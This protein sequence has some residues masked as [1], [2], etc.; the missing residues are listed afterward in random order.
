MRG[1]GEIAY[2][3]EVARPH[4]GVITNVGARAPRDG[5]GS[6][7]EIARAKGELFARASA[8]DGWAVLPASD[9]LITAQAAHRA[10]PSGG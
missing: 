7:D 9:P 5:C 2:L 10:P 8:R 4:I 3:A 6:I 1:H